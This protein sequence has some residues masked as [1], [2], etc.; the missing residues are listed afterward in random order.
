MKDIDAFKEHIFADY[1]RLGLEDTFSFR[2]HQNLPCF[3]TCCADVNIFLSPYD[4]IRL[5]KRLGLTSTELLHRYTIKPFTKDQALPVV[6]LKLDES[7]EKKPCFFVTPQGCSVY[8]DRPW[9]CRMYPIGAASAKTENDPNAPEFY[10]LMKEEPCDGLK[11][12]QSWTIRKWMENQGVGP[13]DE[14]GEHF[15]TIQL[16]PH[17]RSGGSLN[18]QQMDMYYMACY[19]LDRFRTFVLES[20]F[21]QKYDVEP[22]LL[23]KIKTDDTELLKFAFLFLRTAFFSEN[24]IPLKA[25]IAEKYKEKLTAQG[26]KVR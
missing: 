2:C 16:H 22:N 19:D 26:V 9:P 18:P 25:G 23:E 1:P 21:L 10:F 4:I 7:K 14:M 3:N 20:S 13:Y 17:F 12:G 24:L 6:L 15:K 5:K 11:E 8:E